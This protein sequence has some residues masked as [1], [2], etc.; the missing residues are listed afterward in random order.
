MA[1]GIGA[2]PYQDV[3]AFIESGVIKGVPNM[4]QI[5]PSSLDVSLSSE[6]YRMRGSYL[7]HEGETIRDI[8]ARGSLFTHDIAQPLERD[9]I[10]LVRLHETLALPE[11]VRATVSNK[12]SSGRINLRAR[13]LGDHLAGFDEIPAGYHGELWAE[14]IPAS[15][16]VRVHE[17]DRI[18]QMRFYRGD[19]R[20]SAQEHKDLY[21]SESLL[22]L[23]DGT[24]LSAEPWRVGKGLT[25]TVDLSSSERIG[26]RAKQHP[27]GILDTAVYTHSI[28]DFF[29]PIERPHNGEL[30]LSPGE[31]YILST[32][33]TIVI[34]PT[35]AAEMIAYDPSKGEFRSHFAGFFD[36]G[37][38]W[39]E[40]AAKRGTV[41][42]LEVECYGHPFVLRDGQPI[43]LMVYEHLSQAPERYYGADMG[44]HYGVQQG[45]RLA[46][47][48]KSAS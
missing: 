23:Q 10:Y 6:I 13:L 25:M 2:L 14:L 19:V 36:P 30:T 33:E 11:D 22:R 40:D 7:P 24:A 37:F 27:L 34:P 35:Y 16:S 26:W 45:P 44:S 28:E 29:D 12:S 38:G 17:G 20:L 41:G 21:A 39:N 32:K 15:F 9:G 4:E 18:N 46:K 31:F 42:V 47:W 1:N 43:C 5:Q 48:F 8:I 3:H